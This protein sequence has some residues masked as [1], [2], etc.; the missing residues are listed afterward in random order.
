VTAARAETA[1]HRGR[2]D[3]RAAAPLMAR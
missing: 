1:D 3:A 2:G